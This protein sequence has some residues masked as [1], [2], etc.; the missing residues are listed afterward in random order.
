M[1]ERN[2]F[3]LTSR[4]GMNF[5]ASRLLESRRFCS[6]F[7]LTE[8]T[9]MPLDLNFNV[10]MPFLAAKMS[11]LML[12]PSKVPPQPEV[13]DMR[14]DYEPRSISDRV[15][16]LHARS[17]APFSVDSDELLDVKT[18]GYFFWWSMGHLHLQKRHLYGAVRRLL[19]L[20]SRV[21]GGYEVASIF[22]CFPHPHYLLPCALNL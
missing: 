10:C 13:L 3:V 22:R 14:R 12:Q 17:V 20:N 11:F 21:C 4:F 1:T 2:L 8:C 9:C 18:N 7:S 16:C 15:C 5:G 6:L 19:D